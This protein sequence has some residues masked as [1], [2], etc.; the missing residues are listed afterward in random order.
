M[1]LAR[2]FTGCEADC[3]LAAIM[4][5]DTKAIVTQYGQRARAICVTD[6]ESS[7]RV[8]HRSLSVLCQF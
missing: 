7:A 2:I 3:N 4:F 5:R 6:S 1:R 8:V